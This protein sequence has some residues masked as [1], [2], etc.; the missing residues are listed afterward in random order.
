MARRGGWIYDLLG[1]RWFGVL[2]MVIG[3][4]VMYNAY[5]GLKHQKF[6]YGQ[7]IM[8]GNTAR[9]LGGVF[10]L[11]SI[12]LLYFGATMFMSSFTP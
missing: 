4:L 11:V 3:L 1:P 8:T 10:L 5:K 9:I 7:K 2:L 12:L 6:E